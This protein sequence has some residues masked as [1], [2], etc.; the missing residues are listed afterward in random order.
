MRWVGKVAYMGDT[1]NID[2]D[3]MRKT[4]GKRGQGISSGGW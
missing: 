2:S 3:F 4:L 1:R